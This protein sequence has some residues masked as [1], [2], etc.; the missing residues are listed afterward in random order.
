MPDTGATE[1]KIA[2]RTGWNHTSM[3]GLGEALDRLAGG[4]CWAWTRRD[5]PVAGTP[6]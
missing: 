6:R 3:M 2:F 4:R 5:E 1:L